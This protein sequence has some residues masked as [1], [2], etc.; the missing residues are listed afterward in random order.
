MKKQLFFLTILC[1]ALWS[2]TKENNDASTVVTVKLNPSFF[3]MNEGTN[4]PMKIKGSGFEKMRTST[5][6]DSVVYAIQ[7]YEN[8]LPYYYG[9]FNDVS[10]MQL[11][12]TTSLTYKFKV[13]AYKTG[14]GKG[15]KVLADTAG[16]N[17]F[18]PN[19][20]PLQNKF[21]KGDALKDIDLAGSIV[22]GG[23]AKDYPET[24]AFYA[25]KTLTIEK[26]MSNVDF[27]LLRM[28]FGINFTV[29]ALT[30]GN[31]EI[32]VGNDTLKLNSGKTTA[33]TVRQFKSS[34]NTFANIYSNAN[35]FGDSI[36]ITAKWISAGGTIV[37]ATGKYKFLRNYQKTI[38]IQLNSLTN[39]VSFESWKFPTDGLV[40]WY[41][42]NGNAND[43]SGNVNNGTVSG[44]ILSTDRF[45]NPNKSYYFNGTSNYINSNVK[46]PN[47]FSISVWTNV[48]QYKS[49][50]TQN[51]G[52]KFI[53]SIDNNYPNT[54]FEIS[55][56]IPT[57]N[58]QISISFWNNITTPSQGILSSNLTSLNKWYFMTATY[59]GSKL[60]YYF[61][62]KF[63]KS[64]NATFIQNNTN[65]MFGA[66]RVPV[67]S[68]NYN[69]FLQGKLD[70]VGIW[71]RVLTQDEITTL[72]N[73]K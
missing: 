20:T 52:S 67:A 45:S 13:T 53:T 11:A 31:M 43:E 25:T 24:D 70:D 26:G 69:F 15:L 68:G 39:I 1:V 51:I 62:G 50:T 6:P 49:F 42:F 36:A 18:L 3:T 41:P 46:L 65:V 48:E 17:Y 64:I 34:T 58:G 40:A 44:A 10:K 2:C 73:A 5:T 12:L 8:D 32:Y 33:Y 7:V 29:D 61:N 27:T 23:A 9:L 22:L 71:N 19:K 55:G 56:D 4:E 35:S 16:V 47:I 28:G 37:T 60:S 30:T 57:T 72:Y 63:E 21:I 59:D 54:G 66:R 38:N 14:T